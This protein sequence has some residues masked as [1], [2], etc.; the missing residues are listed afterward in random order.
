VN[1]CQDEGRACT[2]QLNRWQNRTQRPYRN[3]ALSNVELALTQ[4]VLND[5][6]VDVFAPFFPFERSIDIDRVKFWCEILQNK[7]HECV[8]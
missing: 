4:K 8:R 7:A 3:Q 2:R 5:D 1:Q 6:A